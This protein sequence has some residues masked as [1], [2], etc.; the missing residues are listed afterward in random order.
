M[1]DRADRLAG[2]LERAHEV[3]AVVAERTDGADPDWALFY[4]WW[5]LN[6]SDFTD[7]LG[8]K[9]SLAELTVE[10]TA[11]DAAYRA[12]PRD[13]PWPAAYAITLIGATPR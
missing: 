5:L 13:L 9:P 10:L 4:A 6:W 2:I 3:H 12:G 7:V 8:G 11:L 1:D